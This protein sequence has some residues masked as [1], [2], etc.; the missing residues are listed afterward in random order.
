M[1]HLTFSDDIFIFARAS[2]TY[3]NQIF[4]ILS[5]YE[6]ALGH[7]IILNKSEV[8][9]SQNVRNIDRASLAFAFGVKVVI[10]NEKYL[11]QPTLVSRNRGLYFGFIK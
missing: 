9:S 6:Q 11:G 5:A 2:M 3:C 8:C 1:N 10:F 4:N 7:K